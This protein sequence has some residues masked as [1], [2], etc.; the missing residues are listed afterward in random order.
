MVQKVVILVYTFVSIG[1]VSFPIDDH[2]SNINSHI[3]SQNQIAPD[4]S[5]ENDGA[6]SRFGY[7]IQL[8]DA[9]MIGCVNNCNQLFPQINDSPRSKSRT[10]KIRKHFS[11]NQPFEHTESFHENTQ[12]SN[13]ITKSINSENDIIGT[14]PSSDCVDQ[15]KNCNKYVDRCETNSRVK[16]ICCA[17]CVYS[18]HK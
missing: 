5:E 4:S 12:E 11:R 18:R 15:I 17:T 7:P 8:M 2:Q 16:T 1:V 6:N 13:H 10:G 9:G 14:T 3:N